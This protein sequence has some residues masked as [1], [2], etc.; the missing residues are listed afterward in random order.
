MTLLPAHDKYE[1]ATRRLGRRVWSFPCLES[2][3]TLALSLAGDIANDGLIL[4]AREQTAGRGQYGRTWTAPPGSSVLMSVLLFPP[5]DLRRPALLTAWATVSV[6]ETI[7]AVAGLDAKVKWPNDV[8]VSGRKVCGILIEQR[9][10]GLVETPLACAVGIGLNVGQAADFFAKAGLPLGASLA[11]LAGKDLD[12][13]GVAES[14]IDRLDE[15]YGRLVAGDWHE[16]D[17]QWQARLELTGKNV[18]VE[19]ADSTKEGR[20][21]AISWEQIVLEQG[22]EII[23]IAPEK[24]KHITAP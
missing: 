7:A 22:N 2:T 19:L 8:Y 15:G 14:L 10:S 11:S 20:L 4:L 17:G 21:L 6:C 1:H 24:V 16:L 18:T 13:R 12:T 9:N 23:T 3:N 5:A